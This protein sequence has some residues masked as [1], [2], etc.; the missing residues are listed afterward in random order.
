MRGNFSFGFDGIAPQLS[1]MFDR[2][3]RI[4]RRIRS[5]WRKSCRRRWRR[6]KAKI[7][8]CWSEQRTR[9]LTANWS[10]WW[11]P[12]RR[13]FWYRDQTTPLDTVSI[14]PH[15]QHYLL[16]C[17][18]DKSTVVSKRTRFWYVVNC[19]LPQDDCIIYW[20]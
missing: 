8:W 11:A 2:R 13:L 1:Y 3:N 6:S 9:R 4:Y 10:R 18:L 7:G 19:P 16:A 15:I 12:I 17:K 14:S 5:D 20:A